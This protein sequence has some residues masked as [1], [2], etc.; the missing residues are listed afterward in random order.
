MSEQLSFAG[1]DAAPRATDQVFFAIFPDAQAAARV[2]AR[3]QQLRSQHG[4]TGRPLAMER[5]HVTL[6]HLGDYVGLPRGVVAAA[7]EAAAAV[8]F[9]PFDIVFDRAMSFFGKSHSQPFVLRGGDGLAAL[10]EF[11]RALGAEIKKAGLWRRAD[12]HF[13]PHVTLLYDSRCVVEQIIEPVSWTVTEFVLVHSL[14]GQTRHI[15]LARWPL[16]S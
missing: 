4:L 16:W 11:Q 12:A 13:T 15:P 14:L 1:I 9:P 2:T 3:M 7:S 8:A 10:V 5:F 6:F